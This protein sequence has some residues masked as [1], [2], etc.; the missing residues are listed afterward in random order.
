M[1]VFGK[2]RLYIDEKTA[3]SNKKCKYAVG[4]KIIPC[5]NEWICVK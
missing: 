4:E 5:K 1:Y 3:K 2:K